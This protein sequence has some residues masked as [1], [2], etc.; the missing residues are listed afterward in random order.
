MVLFL[1][2]WQTYIYLF[3]FQ[4]AVFIFRSRQHQSSVE[5]IRLATTATSSRSYADAACTASCATSCS[6]TANYA[7]GCTAS[8][9]NTSA[10]ASATSI[11]PTRC[12]H[13]RHVWWVSFIVG[14]SVRSLVLY[15]KSNVLLF[16]FIISSE[17]E[18]ERGIFSDLYSPCV[19]WSPAKRI[20]DLRMHS[21]P[22]VQTR[23][24]NPL[25][26]FF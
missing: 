20:W 25:I 4:K 24:Q 23:S 3:I 18:R 22:F 1:S 14:L 26:W 15:K 9:T 8:D 19:Y 13:D 11:V 10:D 2:P 16:W 6:A 5:G 21:R 7:H 17:R 12:D